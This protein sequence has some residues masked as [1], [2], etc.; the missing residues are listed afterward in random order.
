MLKVS[1]LSR[2][3]RD[4]VRKGDLWKMNPLFSAGEGLIKKE[5]GVILLVRA[6]GRLLYIS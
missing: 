4:C 5:R 1:E 6:N 2:G 3:E